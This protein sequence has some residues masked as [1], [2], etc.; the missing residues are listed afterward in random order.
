MTA[1]QIDHSTEAGDQSLP[2]STLV[3][4]FVKSRDQAAFAE[5]VRRHTGL[6]LG[7]CRRVLTDSNDI[8]DAFQAAFLVFVRDAKRLRKSTSVASFLYGIAFRLALKVVRQKQRRRETTLVDELISK[9]DLFGRL[10]ARHDE[11]QLDSE[12]NALPERYRQVLVLR[13]LSGLSAS[14]IADELNTTV[15]AI[16]GLIKRGKDELRR[17]LLRRGVSLGAVLTVVRTAQTAVEAA[18]TESLVNAT[19]QAG[20]AWQTGSTL[21]SATVLS[22][23]AVELAGKELLAMTTLTK[24]A[25]ASCLVVG[26]LAAG[27][28]SVSFMNGR[29][30]SEAA[31]SGIVT[32]LATD[33]LAQGN[34]EF[35]GLGNEPTAEKPE[36]KEAE[37]K[38]KK[39][40]AEQ[41]AVA[42]KS[43]ASAA[44][45]GANAP[46]G[47]KPA[48]IVE[49]ANAKW[50][51]KKRSAKELKIAQ[52]L[53]Q[54]TDVNFVDTTLSDALDFLQQM[55]EIDIVLDDV[56]LSEESISTD[57][58][59][60]LVLNGISL[61]SALR[62]ILDKL[63]LA[64]A[65]RNN[66][67]MITTKT[68]EDKI[69]ETVVYKTNKLSDV[70]GEEL[71]K[72][73]TEIVEPGTWESGGG[74]G[75]I[76]KVG[77]SVVI[78]QT[79]RVHEL[80]VDLL[81]QLEEESAENRGIK[82]PKESAG[83]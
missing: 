12:L 3:E 28:G 18:G 40:V 75:V 70:T 34:F 14:Q 69:F 39:E 31:A 54:S 41:P 73:I 19:I 37:T 24:T 83:F 72:T 35:A 16:E 20:I 55:H 64:Y 58:P 29:P 5:L 66:T 8:E 10:E 32:T 67:L 33:R 42:G 7:V 46:G 38:E 30:G 80:V 57:T 49:T 62:L 1:T 15:G 52:S 53:R 11:F 25:V 82:R 78:R 21:L 23:R 26:S 36:N 68:E 81:E 6:V 76:L 77:K 61:R 48:E 27:I 79:Q 44:G 13:F 9:I 65:V 22:H 50:D 17:R 4:R 45:V 74:K 59:V 51:F 56:A 43:E 63:Q 47:E 71:V 2:D 60:N